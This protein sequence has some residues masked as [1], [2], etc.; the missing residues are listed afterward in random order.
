MNIIIDKNIKLLFLLAIALQILFLFGLIGYKQY[1]ILT[2]EKIV[3]KTIPI[4]PRSLFQGDYARLNYEINRLDLNKLEVEGDK[5]FRGN[6]RVFVELEKGD[7]YFTPKKVSRTKPKTKYFIKGKSGYSSGDNL[8]VVYGIETY[9]MPEGKAKDFENLVRGKQSAEVLVGVS[10]DAFGQGLINK[11]I[12]N[13]KEIDASDFKEVYSTS[14]GMRELQAQM[15]QRDLK[16]RDDL[17]Q[18]GEAMERCYADPNCGGAVKKYLTSEAMPQ[19]IDVDSNPEIM[20]S[21]PFDPLG[22]PYKWISNVGSDY[23]YC[24]FA[25]MEAIESYIVVSALSGSSKPKIDYGNRTAAPTT[26]DQCDVQKPSQNIISQGGQTPVETKIASVEGYV[27]VDA[28]KNNVFDKEEM[29]YSNI[30]VRLIEI[31]DKNKMEGPIISTSAV[32]KGYYKFNIP[33]V[34]FYKIDS[35][36]LGGWN[37]PGFAAIGSSGNCVGNGA[38]KFNGEIKGGEKIT[39]CN[40]AVYFE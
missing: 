15:N 21:V 12:I 29:S 35:E 39:N 13:G 34:G 6:E 19:K 14:N 24:I 26:L 40:W 10:V 20:S 5:Y 23:G 8:S 17:R 37:N 30:T 16:R 7:K 27:F 11:I 33:K 22:V 18:I 28:N 32:I 9:F 2:G 36:P 25:R 4:D 1:A 3:L 31:R 38:G